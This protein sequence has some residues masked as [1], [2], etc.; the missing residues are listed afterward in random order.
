MESILIEHLKRKRE[1]RFLGRN[2]VTP[3]DRCYYLFDVFF[4]L[5]VFIH[6]RLV[7]KK[8]DCFCALDS[9]SSNVFFFSTMQRLL[10]LLVVLFISKSNADPGDFRPP[11]VPLI[12]FSP[13]ISGKLYRMVG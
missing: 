3:F 2:Q 13:H 10:T 4:I 12:V 5:S 1:Y 9:I 6:Y 7:N 11:A 8:N